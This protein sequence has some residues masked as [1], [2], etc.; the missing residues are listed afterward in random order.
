MYNHPRALST[1]PGL[2]NT[3]HVFKEDLYPWLDDEDS[4]PLDIRYHLEFVVSF[5]S[6]AF[7]T[8]A[9]FL[10]NVTLHDQACE[11]ECKYV[12]S[13]AVSTGPMTVLLEFIYFTPFEEQL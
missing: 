4:T 10:D 8:Y 2:A 7:K 12:T 1:D 5:A 3:W 11:K 13:H 9:A 6:L